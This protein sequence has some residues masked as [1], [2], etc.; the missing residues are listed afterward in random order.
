MT[1]VSGVCLL[2]SIVIAS[3][4]KLKI[5]LSFRCKMNSVDMLLFC[6]NFVLKAVVLLINFF[7]GKIEG[8]KTGL[9]VRAE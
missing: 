4:V 8:C 6:L 5:C 9:K 1:D 7:P 3:S 2:I